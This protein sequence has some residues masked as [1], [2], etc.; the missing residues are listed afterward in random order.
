MISHVMPTSHDME[1]WS[2]CDKSCNLCT[3]PSMIQ[4]FLSRFLISAIYNA[5]PDIL[6]YNDFASYCNASG[7]NYYE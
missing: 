5:N 2:T 1:P 7:L 6:H 4:L 3:P